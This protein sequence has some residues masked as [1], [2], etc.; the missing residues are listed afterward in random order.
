M[1][2]WRW[3]YQSGMHG[4]TNAVRVYQSSCGRVGRVIR[5]ARRQGQWGTG[6][7]TYFVWHAPDT[8]PEYGTPEEA[9]TACVTRE[10]EA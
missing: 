4:P 7:V 6:R 5:T 1:R 10:K 2:E 8:A 9:L 3:T